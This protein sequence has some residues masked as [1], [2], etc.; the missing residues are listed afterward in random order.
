MCDILIFTPIQFLGKRFGKFHVRNF[1]LIYVPIR[2]KGGNDDKIKRVET[3][4]NKNAHV[5]SHHK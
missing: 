2:G 1:G 4:G 5:G 3:W